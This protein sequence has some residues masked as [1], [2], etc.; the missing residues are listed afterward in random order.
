[1]E[2]RQAAGAVGEDGEVLGIFAR[3]HVFLGSLSA[4]AAAAL[5]L[6][7][8]AAAKTPKDTPLRYQLLFRCSNF[9]VTNTLT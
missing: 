2:A 6:A 3:R 9:V 5:G 4:A 7:A 1:M 8:D